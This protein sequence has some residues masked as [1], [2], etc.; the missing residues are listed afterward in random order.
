MII[1]FDNLKKELKLLLKI[2]NSFLYS[3]LIYLED[4]SIIICLVI[5]L[6]L[7]RWHSLSFFISIQL[8]FRL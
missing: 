4:F 3:I 6:Q 7:T 8:I 5:F 2:T 1:F